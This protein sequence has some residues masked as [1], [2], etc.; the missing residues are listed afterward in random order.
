MTNIETLTE[1]YINSK[2]GWA[3]ADQ[4]RDTFDG[5]S[6]EEQNHNAL[7]YIKESVNAILESDILNEAAQ[8]ELQDYADALEDYLTQN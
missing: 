6:F 5:E 1:A 7:N 2:H 8:E 3:V 4:F